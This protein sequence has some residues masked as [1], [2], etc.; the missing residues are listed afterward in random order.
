MEDLMKSRVLHSVNIGKA[1]DILRDKNVVKQNYQKVMLQDFYN[2]ETGIAK[3]LED[4]MKAEPWHIELDAEEILED[5]TGSLDPDQVQAAKMICSNPVTVISGKGGCGKTT[6]VKRVFEAA[7]QQIWSQ[8]LKE[9]YNEENKLEKEGL[10]K[11]SNTEKPTVLLT[12][13]T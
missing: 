9:K 13:P 10:E 1:L 6:V 11:N 7:K 12:A 8:A 3:C 4:L 2:Y 5:S